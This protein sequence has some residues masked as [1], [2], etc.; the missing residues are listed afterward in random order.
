MSRA[1]TLF[2]DRVFGNAVIMLVLTTLFWG[3]NTIAGQLAVGR[4]SPMVVVFLRWA[5]VS[6]ILTVTMLPRVRQEW[7]IMRPH[8]GKLCLM[9]L[10]GFT[11]FNMLF[12]MAAHYTTAVNLGILQGS[13]PIFVLIGS[14]LLLGARVRLLQ[15]VGIVATLAGV[16]LVA[17][18]GSLETL[19]NLSINPG[20]GLMLIASFFYA[21]YT[22]TLRNRPQVSGLVFFAVLSV[23]AAFIS[24]PGLIYEMANGTAL[25]PT[26]SGWLVTLYIALFPSCLAQIFFIR[27]V[28]LVGPARAGVFL[29]LVPIFAAALG[30]LILGEPFRWH[31]GLA[32]V[33]V[34]GGIWLSERKRKSS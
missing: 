33:L 16:A 6:V 3:G 2:T 21:G 18:Q 29:N 22:I 17:A 9:A 25:W 32:L 31:H 24:I 8:F 14:V 20:D 19:L 12:Y 5:I 34:L 28:E 10:F 1:A 11:G 13:M 15:V 30:I 23:I 26:P 27:G 7:P 4:V